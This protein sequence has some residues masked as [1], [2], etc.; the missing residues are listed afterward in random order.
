MN[1]SDNNY[2]FVTGTH[3]GASG[4]LENSTV[5]LGDADTKTVLEYVRNQ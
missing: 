5:A 3:A 4:V 2:Y 1:Y